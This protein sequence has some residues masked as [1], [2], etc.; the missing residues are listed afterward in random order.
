MNSRQNNI[1]LEMSKGVQS[2]NHLCNLFSVSERTIRNDIKTIN[3][4]LETKNMPLIRIEK[5]GILRYPENLLE[6]KSFMKASDFYLSKLDKIERIRITSFLFFLA[7]GFMTYEQISEI[8]SV[9]R[10]TIIKD[11][12]KVKTFLKSYHLNLKASPNKGVI[13]SNSEKQIHRGYIQFLLVNNDL[14]DIINEILIKKVNLD[15]QKKK[16]REIISEIENEYQIRFSEESFQLLTF[17]LYFCII[18]SQKTFKES[19][20]E[21][22]TI[23]YAQSLISYINQFLKV[24]ISDDISHFLS[25]RLKDTFHFSV[26]NS[27]D[28]EAVYIQLCVRKLIQSF[29]KAV[30]IDLTHDFILFEALSNH[31]NSIYHNTVVCDELNVVLK[32]IKNTQTRIIQIIQKNINP[33]E[34]F[35]KRSL[36]ESE[37]LYIAIHFCAALERNSRANKTFSVVLVCNAGIGTS[38]LIKE[39]LVNMYNIRVIDSMSSRDI[40]KINESYA[41]LIIST[42]PIYDLPVPYVTVSAELTAIDFGNIGVKLNEI[43]SSL[44]RRKNSDFKNQNAQELMNRLGPTLKN[45]SH[46]DY[47][48]VQQTIFDFFQL[49]SIQTSQD[50]KRFLHHYLS[51]EFIL[52]DEP[53]INWK[54]AIYKASTPLLQNAYI[55]KRYVQ[56]MIDQMEDLGPYFCIAKGVAVPHAGLNDGS[57]KTGMSFLRLKEPI[58]FGMP[59]LDPIRFIIVLSA[60]D[61]QKHI[62]AL[63]NLFNL[64]H[65][66]QCMRELTEAKTPEQINHILR[67]YEY[68]IATKNT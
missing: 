39:K 52:L 29:S 47:I 63:F 3:R 66:L 56:R 24:D 1:I 68:F 6:I 33:I 18:R 34:C 22:S 8:L 37:I 28:R 50:E 60:T 32:N 17:Y 21:E 26:Q 5:H 11:N 15:D 48:S 38:Q 62:K 2:L 59:E 25:L 41:D 14:E 58:P 36:S 46:E 61:Q 7:D 67:K 55:E 9:S 12:E 40:Y 10:T 42:V 13:I 27:H 31:I 54:D 57:Y 19:N 65:N 16:V 51:P 30:K 35:F 4:F 45:I 43:Q 64:S 49:S 23:L 53:C 20:I 44:T